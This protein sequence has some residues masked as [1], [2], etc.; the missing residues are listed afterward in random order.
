MNLEEIVN[1]Y[2][3][4]FADSLDREICFFERLSSLAEIISRAAMTETSSGKRSSHQ[5]A[6]R[7]FTKELETAKRCLLETEDQIRTC[8]TFD[9]LQCLINKAIRTVYKNAVLYV[10]DTAWKIGAKLNL[11]PKTVYL[12]AG[13]RKGTEALGL[14]VK[15]RDT[16]EPHE[17]PVP[18]QRLRSIHI[19]NLLCLYKDELG[20]S[21]AEKHQLIR[22]C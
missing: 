1:D 15:K 7:F 11:E 21:F 12:H 13:T 10:Y 8:E 19:E 3:N 18:M 2:L 4:K 17:L 20:N 9:E 6:Y 14:N 22:G 16:I 5:P